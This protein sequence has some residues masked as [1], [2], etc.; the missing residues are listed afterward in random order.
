MITRLIPLLIVLLAAVG[1]AQTDTPPEFEHGSRPPTS[2]FDPT[3]FLSPDEAAQIAKPLAT[4]RANESIDV[5]VV[6][7]KEIGNA[8]PEHVARQFADAWCDGLLNC[9]VL[10]VPGRADGPWIVPGGR[11]VRDILDPETVAANLADARRRASLEPKEFGKV[12]AAATEAADLLRIWMGLSLMRNEYIREQQLKFREVFE[13]RDRRRKLMIP[14]ILS[15]IVL[16]AG[17]IFG[18]IA[19]GKRCRSR[20]FPQCVTSR[21]LGAPHAGGNDASMD[22]G[23]TLYR[24]D[25]PAQDPP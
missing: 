5:V 17:F 16:A 11:I 13:K 15:A 2:I 14:A 22:L 23:P 19:V 3:G 18:V 24:P 12:R 8:P 10:H 1:S 21:R 7:L 25:S 9:L 20:R 6:I 4:Y